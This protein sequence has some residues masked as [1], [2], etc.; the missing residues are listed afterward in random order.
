MKRLVF[1]FDGTWNE[2]DRPNPTNVVITAQSITPLTRDGTTQIIHYDQGVGTGK[3]DHWTGGMLGEGLIDKIVGAYTF[4]VF[5]YTPGDELFI[6]G[7]SRGAFTARAFVGFVRNL[8]IIQRRHA[9]RISD[10]V[11]LYKKHEAGQS[12]N[13]PELLDFRWKYSPEI[14]ID[15]DE[16]DWRAKNCSGYATGDSLV[17]RIKYLGVWDTVAAM[18]VPSDVLFAKWA[19][20]NEQ[21]FDSDLSPLVVSGRHAVSIDETRVAFTPTLWPNFAELNESLGFQPFAA[22]APYQQQWWPGDHGSVGGGGDIRGLSDGAL[23]WVLDGALKMGLEV[24]RDEASPLFAL[25]PDP[26]ASLSNMKTHDPSLIDRISGAIMS[27]KPRE[28]GPTRIEE[29]SQAALLRWR[30]DAGQLAE[31]KL[32]RP[33]PLAEV[34]AA[35][36]AGDHGPKLQAQHPDVILPP[37]LQPKPNAL[38]RVVYGDGLRKI[39]LRVYGHADREDIILAAN[40]KITDPDRIY[41]GEIIYLPGG[42]E[43]STQPPAP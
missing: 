41:V 34:A 9:A 13:K 21:Y 1:C 3:S 38:Y 25:A 27:R 5:N 17:V 23:S 18:G 7:F 19:D 37:D 32:Y 39:A 12:H 15:T 28:H 40:P 30:A 20:R 36:K 42:P 29:V 14:C 26:Y 24:D 22:D 10:A 6:F 31:R 11:E 43:T 16:D 33:E 8:G 2:L 4:L 35:I